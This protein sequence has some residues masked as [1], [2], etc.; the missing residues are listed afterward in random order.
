MRLSEVLSRSPSQEYVQVEGFLLNKKG[1]T[2]QQVPLSVG[3]V[4]LNYFCSYCGDIR[5]FTSKGSLCCIFASKQIVSIDCILTCGCGTGVQVWFLVECEDD[6][7]VQAPKIRILKRSEKLSRMVKIHEDRY[8]EYSA[9]LDMAE[10][11]YREGLGAGSVVYLR[12]IYEKVTIKTAD[13]MGIAYDKHKGGNPKNFREL[14]EKVDK[15]SSIIPREFS[16]DGYRLFRELSSIVHGEYDE[17]LGLRKFEPL[18]RLVVGILENMKSSEELR[19]AMGS[20]GWEDTPVG[21][22]NERNEKVI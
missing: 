19:N 11:A 3:E 8:G 21:D 22:K 2:G 1:I 5:T 7:C 12:K 17:E 14:L 4:M 6:I 16:R 20:L 15:N 10:R 13:K 18:Y 9:L